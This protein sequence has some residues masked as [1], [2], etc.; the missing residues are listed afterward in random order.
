MKTYNFEIRDE[1]GIYARPAGL[2]V[3][4]SKEE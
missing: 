4:E 3:K 2:L 1:V